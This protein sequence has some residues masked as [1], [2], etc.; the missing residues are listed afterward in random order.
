[1]NADELFKAK[2][3]VLG[4]V[5]SNAYCLLGMYILLWLSLSFYLAGDCHIYC[6]AAFIFS[7]GVQ[8]WN[9][10]YSFKRQRDLDKIIPEPF[11]Y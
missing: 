2:M 4:D 6:I 1:M 7:S 11:K 8:T 5:T 3:D 9:L 10:I